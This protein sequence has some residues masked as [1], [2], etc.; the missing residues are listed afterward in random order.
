V[1]WDQVYEKDSLNLQA[2]GIYKKPHLHPIH[3]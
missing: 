2:G 3:V 1:G